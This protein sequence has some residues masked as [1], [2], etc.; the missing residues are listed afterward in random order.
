[1][2]LVERS[3]IADLVDLLLDVFNEVT[4]GF[5]FFGKEKFKIALVLSNR[6]GFVEYL[7]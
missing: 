4:F 7:L 1:M 2:L 6:D 5:V 3:A